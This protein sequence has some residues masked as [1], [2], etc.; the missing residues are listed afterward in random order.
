MSHGYHDPES[1]LAIAIIVLILCGALFWFIISAWTC[2]ARWEK[3]GLRCEWGP[4]QGCL[5]E[6]PNGK[7]IPDDRYREIEQ[8]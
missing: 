5:V 6:L 8:K 3:S 1:S 2:Y 4:I 7:W